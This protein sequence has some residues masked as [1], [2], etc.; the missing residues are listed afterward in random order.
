VAGALHLGTSGFAYPEWKG[1]FYPPKI[2]QKEMLAFYAQRFG[3]VEINYT[4]RKEPTQDVLA[5]WREATPD[6]FM[7]T[8]KAHQRLTHWLRLADAAE[9]TERFLTEAR[10]LGP[11]LGAVLFQCPPNFRFDLELIAGFLA[12]LD[13]A[14]RYAFEFRHPSWTKARDVLASHRVAWCV[15][16]TDEN[17]AVD[18]LVTAD[19]FAYL[20]L[21]KTHYSDEEL[22]TWAGRIGDILTH[23]TDVFCYFKHE[24]KAAGP[25]H[26]S[27]LAEM[28]DPGIGPVSL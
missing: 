14:I 21:R 2:R 9:A 7:F 10:L 15:A 11:K 13:P 24:D 16:D 28:V 27:R 18:A 6:H 23:G 17:P 8:L 1:V 5:G 26:A 25:R 4:F 12:T 19:P 22:R 3:S 20:R